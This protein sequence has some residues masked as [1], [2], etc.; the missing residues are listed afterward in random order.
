[1]ENSTE[2]I[3]FKISMTNEILEKYPSLKEYPASA[4]LVLTD[5]LC[6]KYG[7]ISQTSITLPSGKV[8][9]VDMGYVEDFFNAF[10]EEFKFIS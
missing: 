4:I 10:F 3:T 5:T 1:M 2:P 9:H 6:G 7:P 8:C